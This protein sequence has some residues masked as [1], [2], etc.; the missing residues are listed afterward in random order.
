MIAIQQSGEDGLLGAPKTGDDGRMNGATGTL[1]VVATPLGNLEDLS[2]RA[3][4]VLGEVDLIAAEDT[5]RSSILLRAHSITTPM[6]SY[7]E[8]NEH[9]RGPRILEALAEGRSVAL[10][11]DAGTPGISDPGYRLVKEA[12]DRGFPVL[13]VPGPSAAIAA[14]SVSGLPTDR[15]LFVGFL[16]R[17]KEARRRALQELRA[18]SATLVVY[19]SPVRAG[20]CLADMEEAWGD[21][22]AFLCREAT[23]IHEEYRRSS[24]AEL[25]Q[26]LGQRGLLKGE[27]VLVVKGA[28]PP[29]VHSDEPLDAIYAR[30]VGEGK[31]RREAVKEAARL[32]GLPAREVYARVGSLGSGESE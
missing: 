8:H 4:R 10:I 22:E 7:F 19:E 18:V 21:R 13:P 2:P 27:L 14:L 6:T 11:S 25:R 28:A 31:T 16:P 20:A 29:S 12:R 26:N 1:Y 30:L 17:K 5:R 32:L 23:K 9:A 3:V 15:F 24:L